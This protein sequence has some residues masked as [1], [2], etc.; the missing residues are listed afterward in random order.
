MTDRY[1]LLALAAAGLAL[2]LVGNAP[3]F[4]PA[5]AQPSGGPSESLPVVEPTDPVPHLAIVYDAGGRGEAGSFSE[6][7]YQGAKRAADHFSAV[8]TEVTSA[9]GDTEADR[10]ARLEQLAQSGHAPIFVLGS[11]YADAVAKVAPKHASTWFG[12]L[13]DA[14]VNA[15]N[16]I[17]VLFHDEQG[18]YLVGAA[19][20]LKSKSGRVGVIAGARDATSA[21]LVAGFA[22]G[23]RAARPKAKVQVAYLAAPADPAKARTAALAMFDA[24]VDVVYAADPAS[25]SGVFEAARARKRW[26]IG[27]DTDRYAAADPSVRGAILTSML[28]RADVATFT[29]TMEVATGVPKDG[30]NVFGLERAGVGY[31]TSGGFIDR[32]TAKLDALAA[33]IAAGEILVPT[34]P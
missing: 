18:S 10:E 3:L 16:V 4:A 32:F 34:K 30:T 7:A 15:P 14:S 6:L 1:R 12:V 29:I 26:A 27:T 5:R 2:V 23:A 20:G 31:A 25:A 21:P 17:G 22:A 11:A 28:R 33:Q 13:G 19:A 24:G 9:P 8:L